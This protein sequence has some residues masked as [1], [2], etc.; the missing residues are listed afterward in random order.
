MD[1][2]SCDDINRRHA[3]LKGRADGALGRL[4]DL[5]ARLMRASSSVINAGF[6]DELIEF[7][8]RGH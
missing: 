1:R 6:R 3:E 4:L 2:M 5:R 8:D 7:I